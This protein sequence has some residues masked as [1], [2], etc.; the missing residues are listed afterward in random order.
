MLEAIDERLNELG[1]MEEHSRKEEGGE[2]HDEDLEAGKAG[3]GPRQPG[4]PKRGRA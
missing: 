3:E 4:G 2:E 1:K